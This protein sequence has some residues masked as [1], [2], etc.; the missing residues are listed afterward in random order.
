MDAGVRPP[1]PPSS[2][3][4]IF[5]E[6]PILGSNDTSATSINLVT[7]D[8]SENLLLKD[9]SSTKCALNSDNNHSENSALPF[10]SISLHKITSPEK[11][12]LLKGNTCEVSPPLTFKNVADLEVLNHL[13][14]NRTIV[15]NLSV[16]VSLNL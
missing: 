12:N 6:I 13:S 16:L 14:T 1:S 8:E 7:N 2:G 11:S 10:N 15:R 4:G 5:S 3:E 9:K